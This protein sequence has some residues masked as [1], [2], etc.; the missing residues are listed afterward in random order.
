MI[1]MIRWFKWFNDSI[2]LTSEKIFKMIKVIKLEIKWIGTKMKWNVI[3]M[4]IKLL[5][6]RYIISL[7]LDWIWICVVIVL[8]Y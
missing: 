4:K 2:I 1:Q 7:M 5:I 6:K 3:V 8:W